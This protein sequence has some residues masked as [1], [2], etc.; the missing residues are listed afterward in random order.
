MNKRRIVL[1]ATTA[2]LGV[3]GLVTAGTAQAATPGPGVVV[4]YAAHT[5]KV[6]PT[7]FQPYKDVNFT[8]VKWTSLTA[9]A[10]DATA[11]RNV[12]TCSPACAAGHY[13]HTRVK[14]HFT[15]VQLSDGHRVFTRAKVTDLATKKTTTTALPVFA[16]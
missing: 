5:V 14:L 10:G 3:A 16:K 4:D 9:T 1:A 8:N 12:N 11:T 15:D 7:A 2:A 13:Q 6:K